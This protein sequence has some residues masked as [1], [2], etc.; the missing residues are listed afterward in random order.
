MEGELLSL[1]D[2]ASARLPCPRGWPHT[3][4]HMGNI[5]W[6]QAIANYKTGG[7]WGG[8]TRGSWREETVGKY[9]QNTWI[10]YV[11]IFQCN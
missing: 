9:D 3:L 10:L 4:E 1:G 7:Q 8:C 11:W 5:N 2:V 6:T